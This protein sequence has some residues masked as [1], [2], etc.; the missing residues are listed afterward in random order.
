MEKETARQ[1]AL[2]RSHDLDT[3]LLFLTEQVARG[4]LHKP[5]GGVLDG[6][7]DSK[8]IHITYKSWLGYNDSILNI[9]RC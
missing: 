8:A 3:M 9:T 5:Q 4:V 7:G 1:A 6:K 2:P